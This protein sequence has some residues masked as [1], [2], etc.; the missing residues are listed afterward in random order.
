MINAI[1]SEL[2][3]NYHFTEKETLW[4]TIDVQSKLV[5]FKI[6][7]R[8]K[9]LIENEIPFHKNLNH[10]GMTFEENGNSLWHV[11]VMANGAE[12]YYFARMLYSALARITSGI[13]DIENLNCEIIK[14]YTVRAV[15]KNKMSNPLGFIIN[16]KLKSDGMYEVQAPMSGIFMKFSQE[17]PDILCKG[18]GLQLRKAE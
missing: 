17:D 6:H 7:T 15:A 8:I 11:T 1:M 9:E 13:V 16:P 10:K 3:I 14:H 18:I 2:R 5:I 12:S 4:S